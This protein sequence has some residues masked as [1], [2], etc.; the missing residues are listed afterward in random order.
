MIVTDGKSH[1]V[2]S[3]EMAFKTASMMAFRQGPLLTHPAAVTAGFSTDGR[4]CAAGMANAR[5]I[6][7]EPMMTVAVEVPAEYQVRS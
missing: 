7:L 2:D 4:F 5:P 1:E 3:S 6:I